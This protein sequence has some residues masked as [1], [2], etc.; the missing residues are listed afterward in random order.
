MAQSIR[1][2]DETAKKHLA[3]TYVKVVESLLNV[4]AKKT[5]ATVQLRQNLTEA[6]VKQVIDNFSGIDDLCRS[7][8]EHCPKPS[9]R[10]AVTDL[11]HNL[12]EALEK[13]RL[14]SSTLG[15]KR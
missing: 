3:S 2:Q 15:V 9:S 5:E 10:N 14:T 4:L 12:E 8:V 13:I 7:I 1:S 11:A 6:N